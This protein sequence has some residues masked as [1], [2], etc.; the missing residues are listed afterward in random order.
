[1]YKQESTLSSVDREILALNVASVN[2]NLRKVSVIMGSVVHEHA[3]R[4]CF[5]NVI[6]LLLNGELN[7][8]SIRH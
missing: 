2:Q 6:M 8:V 3:K 5:L 4:A 1:M 7:H